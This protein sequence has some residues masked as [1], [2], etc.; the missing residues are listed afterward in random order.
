VCQNTALATGLALVLLRGMGMKDLAINPILE[1]K[2]LLLLIIAGLLTYVHALLQPR[3]NALFVRAGGNPV[4]HDLDQQIDAFRLHRK[5]MALICIVVVIT[6]AMPGVHVWTPFPS[7]S[8]VVLV[9]TIGVFTWR[10]YSSVTA[11]G[12]VYVVW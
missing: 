2:L 5:R 1:L 7:W 6:I 12:W 8:T 4:P 9:T 3:I 11:Y 10:A